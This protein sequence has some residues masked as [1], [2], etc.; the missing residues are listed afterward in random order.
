MQKDFELKDFFSFYTLQIMYLNDCFDAIKKYS[1][2]TDK[3]VR[4]KEIDVRFMEI[5]YLCIWDKTII[6][7]YSFFCDNDSLSFMKLINKFKANASIISDSDYQNMKKEFDDFRAGQTFRDLKAHRINISAHF[8]DNIY[9]NNA[10]LKYFEPL[11]NSN[12]LYSIFLKI[13][14]IFK[15][16]IIICEKFYPELKINQLVLKLGKPFIKDIKPVQ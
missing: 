13:V 9:S 2:N 1:I 7:L 11:Q 10:M 3:I 14:M 16:A 15:Y 6:Q 12:T 4:M 8:G 5:A